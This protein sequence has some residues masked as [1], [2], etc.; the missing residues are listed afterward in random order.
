MKIFNFSQN[1]FVKFFGI[2]AIL[3][4]ALL[5]DKENPN[6][7]GH[8]LKK[9]NL[10]RSIE[11]VKEQG[12]KIMKGVLIAQEYNKRKNA[13]DN[14][15]EILVFDDVES[16]SSTQAK[17]G[18]QVLVGVEFKNDN[19]INI[20]PEKKIIINIGE[21]KYPIIERVVNK[22]KKSGVRI[23]NIPNSYQTNSQL[24]KELRE[25]EGD[26][27]F[28]RITLFEVLNSDQDKT[29]FNCDE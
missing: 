12:S 1:G 21:K 25:K 11:D 14:E 9:E 24:I 7:L 15:T 20:I 10:E 29:K 26:D 17:C 18:D 3:Y 5:S 16:F 4:F 6:S 8:K 19:G 2:V 13:R 22:M 28:Y 27:I 23:V